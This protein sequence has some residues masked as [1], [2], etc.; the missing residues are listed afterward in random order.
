[1][2]VECIRERFKS[3]IADREY[4]WLLDVLQ[5]VRTPA[6]RGLLRA[7]LLRPFSR[8][9]VAAVGAFTYSLAPDLS[10]LERFKSELNANDPETRSKAEV[11]DLI[12][13]DLA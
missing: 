10:E 6:S 12:F 5:N 9:W 4:V 1:M 8:N 13:R 7:Q 3:K 2:A 11:I